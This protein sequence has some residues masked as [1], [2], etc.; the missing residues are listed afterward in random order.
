MNIEK[1]AEIVSRGGGGD[2]LLYRLEIADIDTSGLY[3]Y[4][5]LQIELEIQA[6]LENWDIVRK[7]ASA[8]E[9][10]MDDGIIYWNKSKILEKPLVLNNPDEVIS[11]LI[12]TKRVEE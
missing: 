2:L 6:H 9:I 4:S 8:L 11:W 10:C 1:V 3:S 7:L 12:E 5:T